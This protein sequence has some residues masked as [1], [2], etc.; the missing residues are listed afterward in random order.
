MA[1][2]VHEESLER[3]PEQVRQEAAMREVSETLMN[4]EQALKRARR[5]H[6]AVLVIGTERNAEVALARCTEQLEATRKDLFQSAYFGGDQQ[7][8]V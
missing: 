7:R 5:A 4:V 8:L 3:S 1:E 2:P 6:K